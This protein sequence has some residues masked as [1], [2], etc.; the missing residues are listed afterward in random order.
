MKAD[1]S[2]AEIHLAVLLFGLAGLFGK[3]LSFSPLFIVF[4]RVVFAA[5]VLAVALGFRRS[6]RPERF[7]DSVPYFFLGALL[8][9]H[10]ICFFR[11]IQVST[12]AVGLISYATFPL[13]TAF[14][15]PLLLRE[16]FRLQA[17]LWSLVCF[18]GVALLVP[19]YA[20]SEPVFQGV[21][22]GLAAGASFSLL[23]VLNRNM[24]RT[25]TAPVLAFRMNFFAALLLLPPAAALP[26]PDIDLRDVVLLLILGGLCTAGAHTLFI[27]GM[28]TVSARSASIVSSLE[29]VYGILLALAVLRE[30]PP[31]R[32]I[33]GGALVLAAVAAVS[34]TRGKG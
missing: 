29:P 12:V 8:A 19:R 13:F 3:W 10:W 33:L 16:K 18:A 17:V 22:W 2:L 1:R 27:D 26:K 14:L 32:T 23:S 24:R 5:A 34:L 11:S 6:L 9:V 31:A 30:I 20:F 15:E 4:G 28:K 7:S 25:Q 21:L